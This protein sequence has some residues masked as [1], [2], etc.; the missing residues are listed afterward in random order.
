M[1]GQL[2]NFMVDPT[3]LFSCLYVS[4]CVCMSLFVCVWGCRRAAIIED[5]VIVGI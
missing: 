5:I 1:A 2:W 4:V 3:A